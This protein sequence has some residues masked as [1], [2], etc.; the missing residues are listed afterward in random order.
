MEW[1]DKAGK[2]LDDNAR[3]D[4]QIVAVES[5]KDGRDDKDADNDE[6]F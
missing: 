2:D 1:V 5:I 4:N 3:Q 6:D